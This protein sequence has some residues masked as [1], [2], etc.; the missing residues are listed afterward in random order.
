MSRS[1]AAALIAVLVPQTADA[2]TAL[3]A[4]R[5]AT[6]DGSTF[7][8]HADDCANCD[9]R[10]ARVPP[11][12]L[13]G[14]QRVLAFREQYPREVSGRAETYR[15]ANLDPLLPSNL[16]ATWAADEWLDNQTLGYLDA[17]PREVAEALGVRL[18]DGRSYGTLEGLYA[19]ANTAQVAIAESTCGAQPV[20]FSRTRPHI[21]RGAPP[22]TRREGALYDISA[23]SR[24]A[25]ARCPTARC[26]VDLIGY[27]AVTE[28]FYGQHGL[29]E[30]VSP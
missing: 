27:L 30:E 18:G 20:L 14:P 10:F 8:F 16:T 3:M 23:L 1:L 13:D 28:G 6:I 5:K 9:F 12:P 25:L 2:C 7:L 22:A 11:A 24:A 29:P 15:P 4:G 19:I 17:L 26:A 21:G